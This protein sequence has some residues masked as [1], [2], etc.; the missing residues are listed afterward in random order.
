MWV[1]YDPSNPNALPV[2]GIWEDAEYLPDLLTATDPTTTSKTTTPTE[3]EV[4]S[5]GLVPN[6]STKKKSEAADLY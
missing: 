2:E 6:G 4:E 3:S 1:E 5:C